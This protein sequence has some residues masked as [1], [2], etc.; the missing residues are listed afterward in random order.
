VLHQRDI[1]G[2]GVSRRFDRY[3]FYRDHLAPED[4]RLEVQ[5][6][7]VPENTPRSGKDVA[8]DVVLTPGAIV[9][10]RA[11]VLKGAETGDGV[12]ASERVAADLAGVHQVDV[13]AMAPAGL[14]LRGGKS[15]PHPLAAAL[16]DEVQ[17]RP[18]AAAKIEHPPARSDPN[19]LRDVLVLSPLR[20]L[21]RHREVAV[22]FS[23]AEIG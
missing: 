9:L 18:P 13:E 17:Q 4:H 6:A 7:T 1:P 3:V 8:V 16:A 23:A 10:R 22:V 12:E 2:I 19:T 20:V 5:A 14:C 15:H 21:Q 11:E